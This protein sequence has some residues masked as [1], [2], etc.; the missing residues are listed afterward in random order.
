MEPTSRRMGFFPAAER[1]EEDRRGVEVEGADFFP[2]VE[3]AQHRS[4]VIAGEGSVH[5][6]QDGVDTFFYLPWGY[7]D[8]FHVDFHGVCSSLCKACDGHEI[9][10]S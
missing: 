7:P 10:S 1:V 2:A 4:F 8:S 9:P 5:H 6:R 3:P